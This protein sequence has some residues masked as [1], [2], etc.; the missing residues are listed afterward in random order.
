M[1]YPSD[2]PHYPTP[3]TNTEYDMG[4]QYPQ[5]LTND[6]APLAY[7]HNVNTFAS[8]DQVPMYPETPIDPRLSMGGG[9]PGP[10]DLSHYQIAD[11]EPEAEEEEE[12]EEEEEQGQSLESSGEGGKYRCEV[13]GKPYKRPCD[14]KK[15][16]NNH[17]RPQKCTMCNAGFAERKDLA[18]H[19]LVHHPDTAAAK[20]SRTKKQK[21]KCPECDYKG[22]KD[23][24]RRHQKKTHS[25]THK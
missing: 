21:G 6:F 25:K 19:I 23:N 13:C 18:R 14:R 5:A 12:E 22:R 8:G 20:D 10:S 4:E 2:N 7:D 24:V 9:D 17:S 15:H 1:A 3:S 16:Q 11:A